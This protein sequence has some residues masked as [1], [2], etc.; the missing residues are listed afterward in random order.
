MKEL[1]RLEILSIL[2]QPSLLIKEQ[3]VGSWSL[4]S[5]RMLQAVPL[6][7]LPNSPLVC[8]LVPLSN[9]ISYYSFHI[10]N[11][12]IFKVAGWGGYYMLILN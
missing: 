7:S 1:T 6:D 11:M 8:V 10:S 4:N 3:K 5:L 12:V 2:D 9:I